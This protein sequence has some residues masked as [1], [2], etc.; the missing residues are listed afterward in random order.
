MANLTSNTS[1]SEMLKKGQIRVECNQG[2]KQDVFGCEYLVQIVKKYFD[3]Y[4]R[5]SAA[6]QKEMPLGEEFLNIMFMIYMNAMGA[7]EDQI[8]NALILKNNN[9][10]PVLALLGLDS[11]EYLPL[12]IKELT[13]EVIIYIYTY[14]YIYIIY[15]ILYIYIYINIP[16]PKPIENKTPEPHNKHNSLHK[17]HDRKLPRLLHNLPRKTRGRRGLPDLPLHI[18]ILPVLLRRIIRSQAVPRD[19]EQHSND[20]PGPLPGLKLPLKR[21][22]PGRVRALP[23]VLPPRPG[24]AGEGRVSH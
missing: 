19:P 6:I 23:H 22:G 24:D 7:D 9:L 1:L 13:D 10:Q 12:Y 17:T 16:I 5:F 20:Q 18:P 2:G 8:A 4:S 14:I 15:Y 3:Y 11:H 21:P